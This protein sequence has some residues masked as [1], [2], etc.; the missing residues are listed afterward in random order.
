MVWRWQHNGEGTTGGPGYVGLKKNSQ[1][2][3][4]VIKAIETLWEK[5]NM[6]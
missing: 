4:N 3:L 5:S 6:F 1:F 2:G